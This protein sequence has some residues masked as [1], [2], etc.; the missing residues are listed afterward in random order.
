[1]SHDRQGTGM[2]EIATVD[3][4][5]T[6]AEE[7]EYHESMTRTIGDALK[8]VHES[9]VARHRE[10]DEIKMQLQEHSRD[11]DHA[12]KA[13][14]RQAADMASRVGEHAL[15]QRRRLERLIESPYFGRIHTHMRDSGALA[16][17]DIG[18]HSFADPD[19]KEPLVHDWRA[20]ISSMFY[21]YELGEAYYEAPSGRIDCSISLVSPLSCLDG[22]LMVLTPLLAGQRRGLVAP[23]SAADGHGGRSTTARLRCA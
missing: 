13:N 17:V 3:L 19:S 18:V 21:D 7:R 12:D 16:N 11:L 6:E 9:V 22:V 14:L 23:D 4:N 10:M 20:P 15:E 8:A 1:M 5:P 2:A